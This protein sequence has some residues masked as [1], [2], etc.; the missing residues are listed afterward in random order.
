MQTYV[1]PIRS[2]A[3]YPGDPIKEPDHRG[4][5]AQGGQEPKG[6]GTQESRAQGVRNSEV[7]S[8]RV[9]NSRGGNPERREL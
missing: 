5:G 6:S 4:D 1:I 8:A 2:W 9:G 3:I 7:G